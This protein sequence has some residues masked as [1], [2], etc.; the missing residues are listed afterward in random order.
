[1]ESPVTVALPRFETV[2]MA[3]HVPVY[4]VRITVP[5]LAVMTSPVPPLSGPPCA[6]IADDMS[7]AVRTTATALRKARVRTG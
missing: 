4:W 5:G 3:V 2:K 6:W 1:M 7:I